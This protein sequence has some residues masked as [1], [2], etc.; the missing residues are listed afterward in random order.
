MR[1]LDFK[2]VWPFSLL[3]F[4]LMWLKFANLS[5]IR[6]ESLGKYLIIILLIFS[7]LPFVASVCFEPVPPQSLR[8]PNSSVSL[9][10]AR[11]ARRIFF[12]SSPGA[13]S[14][15][16]YHR[17]NDSLMFFCIKGHSPFQQFS[18]LVPKC[19]SERSPKTLPKLFS[20]KK[21]FL[22]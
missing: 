1:L 17:R 19:W 6:I 20:R 7:K 15:V 18:L 21:S 14:L 10:S 2:D 13:Y 16:G 8:S 22:L 3:F 9:S 11:V 4:S 5:W 12:P